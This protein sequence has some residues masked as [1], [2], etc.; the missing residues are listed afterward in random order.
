MLKTSKITNNEDRVTRAQETAEDQKIDISLRPKQLSDF[1]GQK[2]LK[3]ALNVFLTAA[4]NRN[5]SID[6]ILLYGPPGIGK[7]S[8][9][10]II[11]RE[12]D[13]NIVATS[14]PAIERAGDLASIL[15]NLESGDVLFIDEIHRLPRVV[16]EILY[17]AMEDWCLDIV[18][19]KGPGARSVKLEL[20][21]F[22]L[23]GATTRFALLSSPLRDRFGST[24]RLDYYEPS[25]IKDILMR[26]SRILGANI[27]PSGAEEVA[28]RSR[29]TPRIANRLL[30]RCRDFAQVRGNGKID[31]VMAKGALDML[32]VD[33]LG[34]DE[35][36]RRILKT[37]IEQFSGGP[38]GIQTLAAATSEEV[39]TIE[40]I[41]EPYL[42]RTGML[43]RTPKGRVA[44][45]LAYEHLSIDY[46]PTA[47]K[48]L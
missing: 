36:D 20:P 32:S 14:G 16:E 18:L 38:V 31:E 26:S 40:E 35:N 45:R 37:I 15:T 23:I 21:R 12:M 1:V 42:M 24:Y 11:A 13:V 8:L 5:E 43:S 33:T 22:T 44:T 17:P 7:T 29:R 34:L 47:N 27:D 6:H 48:L 9:A 39:D 10:N 28:K 41:Y 2:K 3:E 25:E 46:E 4:K 19:G 30:R